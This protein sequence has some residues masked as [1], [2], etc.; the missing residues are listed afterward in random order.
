MWTIVWIFWG[1]V[2]PISNSQ[3]G[4]IPLGELCEPRATRICR[5]VRPSR[6][7]DAPNRVIGSDRQLCTVVQG[8]VST[9]CRLASLVHF[10][11]PSLVSG[12]TCAA[13]SR[14]KPRSKFRP[15]LFAFRISYRQV[16]IS[17]SVR[18]DETAPNNRATLGSG[19][20]RERSVRD[21]VVEWSG[22]V[23]DDGKR[24]TISA[25]KHARRVSFPEEYMESQ[26]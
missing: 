26:S 20:K 2:F 25:S 4:E 7:K 12:L 11:S 21:R 19:V 10:T 3:A 14:S 1:P 22:E 9:V 24:A 16:P 6:T 13:W 15:G 18:F 23:R 17:P 8:Y 5:E